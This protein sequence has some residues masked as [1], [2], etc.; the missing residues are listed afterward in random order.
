MLPIEAFLS[1]VRRRLNARRTLRTILWSLV[2]GATV[3]LLVA[4]VYFWQG[5]A[6]P[7]IWYAI[8]GGLTAAAAIAAILMRRATMDEASHAADAWFGLKDTVTSHRQFSREAKSGGFYDMQAATT[9]DAVQGLNTA[10]IPLALPRRLATA[11]GVLVLGASLTAFKATSPAVIARQQQEGLTSDRTAQLQR[12]LEEMIKELEKGTD[13]PEEQK[14]L[15]PDELKKW[16]AELKATKDIQEAMRQMAE[17]ERKL[18]KAA[19]ALSQKREEQVLQKA[20]E[21]LGKE[22]NPAAREL[23]KKLKNEEYKEAAKDLEAMK[24]KEEEGQKISEKRKDLVRLKAAAKRMAAAARS[25]SSKSKNSNSQ[26]QQS[27]VSNNTDEQSLED[28]LN[29]LEQ[30]AEEYDDALED[31]E[32][33][34]KL[35]KLDPSKLGECEKCS[36][37][38]GDKLGKLGDKLKKLGAKKGAARKLLGMARN[39]G[40][41]QGFLAGQCNSPF[42]APGGK[43]PGDGTIESRR[44]GREDIVDNGQTTQLKGQKGSGPSLSKIESADDGTG[45]SHRKGEVRERAFTKQFESFV[46]REDVPED[47]K[48]GVKQYFESIHESVPAGN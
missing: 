48:Q 27:Q 21:E 45:V 38:L 17:L 4:S 3:V 46:S 47:V 42:A 5:Y 11:C 41:S 40:K 35:G 25:Q 22:E 15:N 19:K 34:E 14:L 9:Q 18:D 26:G 32:N 12:D 23:A 6:V 39:A 43:K 1:A 13:D 8:L 24:P 44:E 16:V 36:G 28:Q 29:E 37:K 30:E 2:G 10:K 20:A 33:M 31:A 7:K